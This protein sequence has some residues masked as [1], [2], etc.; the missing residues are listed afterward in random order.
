MTSDCFDC[1]LNIIMDVKQETGRVLVNP[2]QAY[3]YCTGNLRRNGTPT[4]FDVLPFEINNENYFLLIGVMCTFL[5]TFRVA[6]LKGRLAICG[7][8]VQIMHR[9][10]L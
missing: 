5:I 6:R 10:F 8:R 3:S 9:F 4:L 1:T 2:Q 7:S